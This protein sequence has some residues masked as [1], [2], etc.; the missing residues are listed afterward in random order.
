VLANAYFIGKVLYPGRFK[1]I[2]PAVKADEI[3]EYL[4]GKA[5]FN[6]MNGL[7]SNMAYQAVLE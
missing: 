4:V 7:F 1:D 6:K 2:E 5:V 3:Y